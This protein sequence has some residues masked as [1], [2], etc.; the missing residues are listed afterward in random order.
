MRIPQQE[1]LLYRPLAR[2]HLFVT[3][4]LYVVVL[5]ADLKKWVNAVLRAEV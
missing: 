1:Q 3:I 4:M 5:G 2:S